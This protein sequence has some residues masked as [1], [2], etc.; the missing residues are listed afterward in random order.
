MAQRLK[1]WESPRREGRNNK[2]KGG[3]ARQRQLRKQRQAL[4]QKLKSDQGENASSLP[5]FL[6]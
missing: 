5:Y 6:G 4:R 3:S 1:S 2:G